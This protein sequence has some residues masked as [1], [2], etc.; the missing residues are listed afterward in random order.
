M[1]WAQ[2]ASD[3]AILEMLLP[4]LKAEGFQVFLHPSRSILPPFMQGYQP[5]A[6]AMKADKKLA[7]EGKSRFSQAEPHIQ[8]L[9]ELFSSHP[10][11]ELR[12]IYASTQNAE[13]TI[14]VP[15]RKLVLENLDRLLKIFDEAGPVPA[16]LTGWSVFEAAARGLI[17][18]NL[19]RPQTPERLLEKLA[20][21]GYI[22]PGEAAALRTLGQLRNDAAHGRLDAAVTRDQL[23][24]LVSVTHTL[25][26]LSEGDAEPATGDLT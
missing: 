9:Q 8:R 15:P 6:I 7:I 23:A 20:S 19:G 14:A 24:D 16:L 2:S 5:D 26:E 1:S 25:L 11:W 12:I 17:P 4:N 10:D 21:E 18:G 13:R 22:T 3:A